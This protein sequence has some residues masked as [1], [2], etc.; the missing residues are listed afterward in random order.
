MTASRVTVDSEHNVRTEDRRRKQTRNTAVAAVMLLLLVACAWI[1]LL[2]TAVVPDVKGLS[3]AEASTALEGAGFSAEVAEG[4]AAATAAP[5]GEVT[6]VDTAAAPGTVLGQKPGAGA[7]VLRGTR[8]ILTVA[9]LSAA[10]STPGT[11]EIPIDSVL[12]TGISAPQGTSGASSDE[13]MYANTTSSGVVDDR[14][15]IPLVGNLSEAAALSV[16]RNA[17]YNAVVG[18]YN[19]T[20]AGIVAGNVYYQSPPFGTRAAAGTTVTIWVSTGAPQQPYTGRP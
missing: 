13:R 10:E 8:V 14:P 18:G 19:P 15:V 11:T 1:G 6:S 2:M 7:R 9:T 5:A 16:L 4:E 17:G 20:T 3:R 12:P